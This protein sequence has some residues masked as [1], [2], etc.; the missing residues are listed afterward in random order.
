M[1]K[2]SKL[3]KNY[4][5]PLTFRISSSKQESATRL[6]YGIDWCDNGNQTEMNGCCYPGS[7]PGCFNGNFT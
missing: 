3:K 4:V 5:K 6:G 1:E 7:G 2:Q